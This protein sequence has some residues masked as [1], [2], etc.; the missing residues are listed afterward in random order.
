MYK[1]SEWE[2]RLNLNMLDEYDEYEYH[3]GNLFYLEKTHSK[4]F[5]CIF[6]SSSESILRFLR[7]FMSDHMN[8]LKTE[9]RDQG[10][11]LEA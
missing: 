8:R 9:K 10:S 4:A 5:R 3:F 2:F 1:Y 6:A 11:G 7:V